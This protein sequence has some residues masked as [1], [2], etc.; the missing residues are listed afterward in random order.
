MKRKHI[1]SFF[2][3]VLFLIPVFFVGA[4]AVKSVNRLNDNAVDV[5]ISGSL[6]EPVEIEVGDMVP[7]TVIEGEILPYGKNTRRFSACM[8]PVLL[9]E[10]GSEVN[11]GDSLIECSNKT[12]KADFNGRLNDFLHGDEIILLYDD[13]D[14]LKISTKVSP[15]L[16]DKYKSDFK[17]DDISLEF[18]KA[19]KILVDGSVDLEYKV[20]SLK[21]DG[22]FIGESIILYFFDDT[23]LKNQMLV[24]KQAVFI[25]SG[26]TVV[27]VVEENGSI[28][29][30]VEVKV[31]NQDQTNY[32][33]SFIDG[34]SYKFYDPEYGVF[35]N[36]IQE[37]N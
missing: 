4:K 1:I 2:V 27:R 24:K 36:S 19:S 10:L 21:D 31:L 12:I 3:F 17:N 23:Q 30:D 16:V 29:G 28:I 9:L 13:F 32:S 20:I 14:Q 8:D 18:S 37:D 22:N 11:D 15:S 6:G 5:L 35:K 34:T 33:I 25:K 26:R 7:A